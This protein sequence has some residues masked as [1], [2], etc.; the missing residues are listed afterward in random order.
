MRKAIA[1]ALLA[2]GAC[3]TPAPP[4]DPEAQVRRY[5]EDVRGAFA[6]RSPEALGAL[7]APEIARPMTHA[8]ILE[9][10]RDFFGKH[11]EA[12]FHV[13][14]L[15]IEEL[16]EDRAT[17]VLTYRVTTAGGKGDFGG[18][19]RDWLSRRGGRWLMTAW[20]KLD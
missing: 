12:A 20:E 17:A 8:R 4:P 7:F 1:L 3:R 9:W 13:D 16:S 18:R 5:Y 15:D 11:R 2:C 19:E 10:G 14:A 6:E